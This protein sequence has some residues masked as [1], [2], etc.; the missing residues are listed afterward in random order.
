[1]TTLIVTTTYHGP[2]NTRGSRITVKA[3]G[4]SKSVSYNYAASDVHEYSLKSVF[5]G[6]KITHWESNKRGYTYVI[7]IND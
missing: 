3:N 7:E 5:P 2:T 1:M 6:C 4:K